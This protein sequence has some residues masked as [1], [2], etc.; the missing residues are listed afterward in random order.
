MNEKWKRNCPSVVSE[1]PARSPA[2]QQTQGSA[3]H[4]AQKGPRPRDGSL[5]RDRFRQR[6]GRHGRDRQRQPNGQAERRSGRRSGQAPHVSSVTDKGKAAKA[7]R[8]SESKYDQ[9]MG[10]LASVLEEYIPQ[11][12]RS[13]FPGFGRVGVAGPLV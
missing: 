7:A 11:A 1:P 12:D 8:K 2:R 3:A 9:Q 5:G 10:V 4:R 6:D 13:L